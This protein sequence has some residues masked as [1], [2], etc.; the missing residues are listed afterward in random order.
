MMQPFLWTVQPQ[1]FTHSTEAWSMIL[2][3]SLLHKDTKEGGG[4]G[5]PFPKD[6]S[7][8]HSLKYRVETAAVERKRISRQFFINFLRCKLIS[9][10]S[11]SKKNNFLLN[12][13]LPLDCSLRKWLQ[14]HLLIKITVDSQLSVFKIII[15]HQGKTDP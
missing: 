12:F 2:Q 1:A 4:R 13:T 3:C 6:F 10:W 8:A 5:K 15:S 7:S 11:L 14:L 9:F